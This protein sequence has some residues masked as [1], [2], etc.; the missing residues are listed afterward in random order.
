SEARR[1]ALRL[2]PDKSFRYRLYFGV[3]K[4]AAAVETL[5]ELFGG[6]E[7]PVR[8]ENKQNTCY[9]SIDVSDG[10]R[11]LPGALALST[12]PWAVGYLGKGSLDENLAAPDW[13]WRFRDYS[14]AIFMSLFE[15]A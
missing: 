13:D 14:S 10:G 15:E 5:R 1:R 2:P 4:S 11:L 3:F 12:L 7:P 9:G 8:Y 6:K